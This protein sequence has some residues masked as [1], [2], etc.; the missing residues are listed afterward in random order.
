MALPTSRPPS[1]PQASAAMNAATWFMAEMV[2]TISSNMTRVPAW[3]Q[4][5]A[6]RAGT[7]ANGFSVAAAQ[8]VSGESVRRARG[9][10]RLLIVARLRIADGAV[11]A[12]LRTGSQLCPHHLVGREDVGDGNAGDEKIVGDDAAMAAPPHRLGAHDGA[13]LRPGAIEQLLEA[14]AKRRRQGVVRVVAK[15][16]VSPEAIGRGRVPA[17]A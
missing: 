6:A 7:A 1:P 9:A 17:R 14:G 2:P 13:R 15:C 10:L 4:C 11:G 5:H 8:S 16:R 3:R 12:R